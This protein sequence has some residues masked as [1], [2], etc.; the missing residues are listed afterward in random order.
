[1]VVPVGGPSEGRP[2]CCLAR[3]PSK[4]SSRSCRAEN[5]CTPMSTAMPRP[6]CVIRSGRPV[7]VTWRMKSATRAL[8]SVSGRT[9]WS[10]LIIGSVVSI[11]S[12]MYRPTYGR[13]PTFPYN[14]RHTLPYSS[15]GEL[16]ETRDRRN[17]GRPTW[18]SSH[19][20][21]VPPEAVSLP[22]TASPR[23]FGRILAC[24]VSACRVSACRVSACRGCPAT[25]SG[26]RPGSAPGP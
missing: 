5:S 15:P 6:R 1:M 21:V 4:N 23:D 9:S 17:G 14:R 10:S 22:A 3:S 7:T 24:R 11:R 26:G 20:V 8:T 12:S 25:D 13:T 2:Y 16:E 18:W 19:L